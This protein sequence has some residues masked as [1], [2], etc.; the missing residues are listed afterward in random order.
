[1]AMKMINQFRGGQPRTARPVQI[2]EDTYKSITEASR[3]LG[4]SAQ[5]LRY[6]IITLKKVNGKDAKM[7]PKPKYVHEK[8]KL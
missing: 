7:L 2:G 5:T 1:M 6:Q 4:I 3:E 8:R